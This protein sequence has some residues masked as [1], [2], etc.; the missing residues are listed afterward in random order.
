M[1]NKIQSEGVLDKETEQKIVSEVL[2]DFN[3]RRQNRKSFETT[4]Q[5]NI[6]F[7]LG[8]QYSYINGNNEIVSEKKQYFWQEREVY[9]HIAPI[10]DLRTAKLARVKPTLTVLPFSDDPKDIACAKVSKNLIKSVCYDLNMS[11]LIAEATMWSEITGTAFYKVTWNSSKGK[12]VGIDNSGQ[13]LREGEVELSVVS[14]FEIFPDNNT[15]NRIEDCKSI[16]HARAYHKDEVKNIWGIDVEGKDTDVFS[17]EN[18]SQLGGLGYNGRSVGVGRTLRHD[19]VIVIERYEQ[20]SVEYPNGRLIIVAGA[21]LVYMGELPYVNAFDGKRAFPFI[22]QV[23]LNVPNSFWGISV[24]ERCIP[25]QRAYNAVK[26]R[27]HEFLNRIAMGVL[28]VEDGSL[29]IENLEEEGLSPGKVLV[30]RQGANFP[31]ML[32]NEKVPDSFDKEEEKLIEEFSNISGISDL[33]H[34]NVI[35]NS[36]SGVVLQLLIEQ[37]EARLTASINEIKDSVKNVAK[38]ILRLYKQFAV[39]SHSTRLINDNGE[40]E[41]LYWEN[42]DLNCEDIVFE[43]ENEFG[44]TLAQ[45]RSMIYEVLNAGLLNDEDGGMSISTRQKVLEQLGFGILETT[46][47]AKTLHKNRANKENYNLLQDASM[48]NPKFIDEHDIH[49]NE[50]ICFALSKDFE[51][52][53]AKNPQ[54]ENLMNEHIKLHKQMQNENTNGYISITDTNN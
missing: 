5:L 11:S 2:E 13:S 23:C 38:H 17:L 48:Q 9:N 49:I 35:Y 4:W 52:A 7:L 36:I 26:N 54:L 24:I 15:Y 19:Q 39:Y 40:I 41:M 28:A 45:K 47:D 37:D 31:Q 42:S 6:N 51:D 10:V 29:D 8:N 16:I 50:H 46:K 1:E 43:T 18:T 21:K 44:Q 20:A 32:Q 14:P 34:Q 12:F 30:Y 22:K 33:Q 25:I 3:T 53:V 27:K